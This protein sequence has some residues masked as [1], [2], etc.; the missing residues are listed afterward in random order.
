MFDRAN[1]LMYMCVRCS[2]SR[3]LS[4]GVKG[5]PAYVI[6]SVGCWRVAAELAKARFIRCR[7]AR[8]GSMLLY[9][10]INMGRGPSHI[11]VYG[12]GQP[13]Q[14]WQLLQSVGPHQVPM[15]QPAVNHGCVMVAGSICFQQSQLRVDHPVHGHAAISAALGDDK[16]GVNGCNWCAGARAQLARVSF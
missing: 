11:A 3:S 1:D 6:L 14:P 8:D 7:F 13:G 9:G 4:M 15:P 16:G 5:W 2:P 10:F 12:P